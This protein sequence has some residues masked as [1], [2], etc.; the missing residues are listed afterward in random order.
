MTLVCA[1]AHGREKGPA[2][3]R[4]GVRNKAR[5]RAQDQSLLGRVAPL[6]INSPGALFEQQAKDR[7][8]EAG[9][10]GRPY[11]RRLLTIALRSA[12]DKRAPRQAAL[13]S[14]SVSRVAIEQGAEV[15]ERLVG[16]VALLRWLAKAR[17]LLPQREK[18]PRGRLL[19]SGWF[20]GV[21][22]RLRAS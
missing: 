15:G 21:C 19:V 17:T 12:S 13:A 18:M 7:G 9:V 5:N 20:L 22:A 3:P 4:A 6:S 2:V 16:H 8:S 11:G 14:S 1:C 10:F